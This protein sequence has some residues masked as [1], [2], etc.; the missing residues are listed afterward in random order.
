MVHPINVPVR[1]AHWGLRHRAALAGIAAF[2]LLAATGAHAQSFPVKPVR[3]ISPFEAGGSNDGVIRPVGPRMGELLGQQVLVENRP[4]AGGVVGSEVVARANPDGYTLLVGTTSTHAINPALRKLPYDAERDFAPVGL[5]GVSPYVMLVNP[6]LPAKTV[7]EMIA[8]ARRKPGAIDYGSGGIGTPGHLAGAV[9]AR[10][11]GTELT[12]VPYKSGA[13][14]ITDAV[15]GRISMVFTTMLV[16]DSLIEAGRVRALGV[17]TLTR[18]PRF[19]N[20]PTVDESGLPGYEF[21]LWL[22]VLAPAKTPEPT[23]TRLSDALAGSLRDKQTQAALAGQ[24]VEVLYEAPKTFGE[25][26]R[27]ELAVYS[28]LIK[29]TGLKVE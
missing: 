6:S 8:L 19:P 17:T 22:G 4:G 20:L 21:T 9:F 2:S 18:L 27:R 12:H 14:S 10:M 15:A 7:K 16:A 25:R 26:I 11:T 1:A 24:S 3:I 29:E 23:I 28:K 5:V 13:S